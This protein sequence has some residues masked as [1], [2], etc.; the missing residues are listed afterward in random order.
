MMKTFRKSGMGHGFLGVILALVLLLSCA[1]PAIACADSSTVKKSADRVA[2]ELQNLDAAHKLI[3]PAYKAVQFPLYPGSSLAMTGQMY[4]LYLDGATSGNGQEYYALLRKG[5]VNKTIVMFMG[6]GVS[7]NQEMAAAPNS[8]FTPSSANTFYCDDGRVVNDMVARFGILSK[9]PTNPFRDWNVLFLPYSTGD[10]HI[11]TGEYRYTGKDGSQKILYHHGYT[12]YKIAIDKA[13]EI[14]GSQPDQLLV[15]GCSAGGF[16]AALLTETV[17]RDFPQCKDITCMVDS[18]Y[19][20]Y[21]GWE[22]A[23]KQ[24]WKAPDTISRNIHSDN[25]TLDALTALHRHAPEVKILFACSVRDVML[26]QYWNYVKNGKLINTDSSTEQFQRDLKEMVCSLQ[27]DIPTC[28]IYLFDIPTTDS[29]QSAMGLTQHTIFITPFASLYPVDGV[30]ALQWAEQGVQGDP[31]VI[32][33][34]LLK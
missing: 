5:K 32:G 9:V 31:K 30:T 33:L 24:I 14:L 11:G 8:M 12:N 2:Y 1:V 21:D 10:F 6:G 16:A 17:M 19:I 4:R 25:I 18:G 23:A 29:S 28:G 15:T 26:S 27:K 20:L 3:Y 34:S 22:T 7:F 13:K